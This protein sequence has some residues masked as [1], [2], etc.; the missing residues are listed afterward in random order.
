M[1]ATFDRAPLTYRSSGP[2][3][4][5]LPLGHATP[6]FLQNGDRLD[7]L[8]RDDIFAMQDRIDGMPFYGPS[9]NIPFLEDINEFDLSMS[10][11]MAG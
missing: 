5:G 4:L 1:G 10:N 3:D 9:E 6:V 8:L 2:V 7:L 11:N